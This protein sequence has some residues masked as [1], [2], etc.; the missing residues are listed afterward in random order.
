MVGCPLKCSFCPQ[1]ALRGSYGKAAKYMSV[2]AF[3][4][5]LAK[6]PG[7]VRIDFSG[8]SEPWANP[9]ATEMLLLAL[10]QGRTVAIYTTLHGMGGDGPDCAAII[11]DHRDQIEVLCLHL[12]DANGNMRGWKHSEEY[13]TN[14]R[15]FLDLGPSLQQFEVMTMDRTGKV[16]PDLAHMGLRLHEWIGHTRA[17]NISGPA[18]QPVLATPRHRSAVACSFTPFYDQNVVLPNGDVV[19]CCYDYSVRHRIGNLLEQD[20][21]DMFAGAELGR[22]RAENMKLEFSDRSLCRTCDRARPLNVGTA[23]QYW[24]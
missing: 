22:L 13:E 7:H 14:L 2:D 5:I 18:G 24:R 16:H 17:G 6:V 23:K 4:T 3:K 11:S 15:R 21:Y 1:D 8:M 19:L 10:Q 20:Y 9:D 12:P